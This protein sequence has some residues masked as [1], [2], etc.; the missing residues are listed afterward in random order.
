M[1]R[2]IV[3]LVLVAGAGGCA[4]DPDRSNTASMRDLVFLTR[5]GCVNTATMRTNLD[6]AL[7]AMGLPTDYRFI[8]L[9]TLPK[10]DA[11]LGYPTPTLLYA[12]HDVFGMPEPQP[13]YPPPT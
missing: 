5:E 7:R 11:R 10:D 8:D 2:I 9:E 4:R 3:V 12:D 13:P 6:E 1:L